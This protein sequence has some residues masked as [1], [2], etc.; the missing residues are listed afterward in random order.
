M[1]WQTAEKHAIRITGRVPRWC[2][3]RDDD[4]LMPAAPIPEAL[5]DCIALDANGRETIVSRWENDV[6]VGEN[7][8]AVCYF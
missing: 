7:L 5:D 2:D 3:V 8:E 6:P 4:D 1:T